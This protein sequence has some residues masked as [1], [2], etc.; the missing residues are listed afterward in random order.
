MFEIAMAYACFAVATTLTA[1]ITVFIPLMQREAKKHPLNTMNQNKIA[2]YIS[3]ISIA[4]LFAPLMFLIIFSA[5][6]NTHFT[7]ALVDS[8]ENIT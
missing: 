6:L 3:F 2:A 5:T 4:L 7:D 1:L 8:L